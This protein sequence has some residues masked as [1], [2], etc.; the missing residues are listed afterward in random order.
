MSSFGSPFEMLDQYV[1]STNNN[2][3][4]IKNQNNIGKES[5]IRAND[6]LS[7]V[8][9]LTR[10]SDVF[11][12][13]S[14]EIINKAK[15]SLIKQIKSSDLK[16]N[17]N[18][19]NLSNN[20]NLYQEKNPIKTNNN[21]NNKL[22]VL[23]SYNQEEF[24]SDNYNY[25]NSEYMIKNNHYQQPIVKEINRNQQKQN[26]NST[27]KEKSKKSQSVQTSQIV[28][29]ST[30][31]DTNLVPKDRILIRPKQ[32]IDSCTTP[33]SDDQSPLD[34]NYI[35]HNNP[36]SNDT[37]PRTKHVYN[38]NV[39]K[40]PQHTCNTGIMSVNSNKIKRSSSIDAYNSIKYI[41][42]KSNLNHYGSYQ[43]L[44]VDGT[45]AS[46]TEF[47]ERNFESNVTSKNSKK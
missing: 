28:E 25:V 43:K 14:T 41:K 13:K 4:G 30:Q 44:P 20:Q 29:T 11:D 9:F 46:S 31:T 7:Y 38:E 47:E 22:S 2:L 45:A 37:K 34:K 16:L 8:S 1:T 3:N 33:P 36:V 15:K 17:K 10:K 35:I 12:N 24:L 39:A 5:D 32:S 42:P 40:T 6:S 18:N 27:V 26:Q 21:N 23:T 19:K